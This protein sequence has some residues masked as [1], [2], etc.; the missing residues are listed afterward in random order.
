MSGRFSIINSRIVSLEGIYQ[1]RVFIENGLIVSIEKELQG[2]Q[3]KLDGYQ[4]IDAKNHFLSPGFFEIHF[5][6]QGGFNLENINNQQDKENISNL[7]DFLKKQGINTYL[8]TFSYNEIAIE[9]CVQFYEEL[10]LFENRVPGIYIEGPFISHQKKGALEEGYIKKINKRELSD[11]EKFYSKIGNRIKMLTIAPEKENAEQIFDFCQKKNIIISF[12]HSNCFL[13]EAQN[14]I[15]HLIKKGRNKFI[16]LTHLFNAM[17]PIK[18]RNSGLAA[19]P[20][21]DENVFFE[22]IT[23]GVHIQDEILIMI[24]KNLNKEKMII[25]SDSTA[26]AGCPSGHYQHLGKEIISNEEGVFYKENKNLF[27]GSKATVSQ[28]LKYFIEN[29]N[30]PVHEAV[31]MVTNNPAKLLQL[32]DRGSIE[33]GKKADLILLDGNMNCIENFWDRF[34]N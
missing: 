20:F 24:E 16:N 26:S 4:I 7:D 12:G 11:F 34:K 32:E 23:D 6:G 22:V 13:K 28:C 17:S 1:G 14:F 30:C 8:P 19:L 2:Y 10:N 9:K 33:I 15:H 31:V 21:I 27:V 3:K 29:A 5:H 25:V 18:H